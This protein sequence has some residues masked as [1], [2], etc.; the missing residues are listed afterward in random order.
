MKWMKFSNEKTDFLVKNILKGFFF[1]AI[2]ILI[3]YLLR[4]GTTEE[5]R[6]LWFGSIYNNPYLVLAVFVG[7]EIIFGI[8]PPE[9]FMLWSM[10]TGYLGPYF[11][12]IGTLS[13]IS[14]AAGFLNF[15]IGKFLKGKVGWLNGENKYLKKYQKMFEQYGSYLVIVASVT[16]IPFSA[17]ALL[18]GA[19]GLDK[20]IYLL[21]SLFRILRYFVYAY[22]L[23]MIE[24]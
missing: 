21:Y 17:V 22:I 15:T 8:I 6:L 12:S 16:P 10:E 2:L 23:W 18:A 4:R 20:T 24:M 5:D 9:I 19:G 11:L 7:S 13:L 14:Y 3:F 1:L